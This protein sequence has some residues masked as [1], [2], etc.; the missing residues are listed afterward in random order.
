MTTPPTP[1]GWYPDPAN[2][3]LLRYWDNGAWTDATK[4]SVEVPGHSYA[5][6]PVNFPTAIR[7]GYTRFSGRA[8]RSEYWYFFLFSALL[9][10]LSFCILAMVSGANSSSGPVGLLV[11]VAIAVPLLMAG[12]RRYHDTGRSGWWLFGQSCALVVGYVTFIILTFAGIL[13]HTWGPSGERD[14][15]AVSF[16]PAFLSAVGALGVTI[17]SAV[18]LSRAGQVERNRYDK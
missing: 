13:V 17:W 10:S 1:T 15:W 3:A 9:Y 4:S 6:A 8:S 12:V 14:S 7:N 16:L 5:S 11:D 2:P 18:W